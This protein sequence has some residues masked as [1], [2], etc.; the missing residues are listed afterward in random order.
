MFSVRKL[1]GSRSQVKALLAS[2]RNYGGPV[3]GIG[4]KIFKKVPIIGLVVGLCALSFQIGVLFP[5]H[6][7]LSA[8]FNALE[9]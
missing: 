5:W 7:E 8:Q 2:K 3:G 4:E 1:A 9:V 6:A